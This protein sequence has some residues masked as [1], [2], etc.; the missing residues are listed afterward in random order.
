RAHAFGLDPADVQRMKR[1]VLVRELTTEP[2]VQRAIAD[3]NKKQTGEYTASERAAADAGQLSPE[4]ADYIAGVLDAESQPGDEKTLYEVLDSSRGPEIINKL[5]KDGVFTLDEKNSLVDE[6]TKKVT[7]AGKDRV[8]KMLLG[9]LF[10]DSE[11][12]KNT[13]PSLRNKLERV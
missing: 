4:A 6:G 12:I 3:F 11:Q 5:V 1:P 13:A 7:A 10:D 8:S 2:D 9:A